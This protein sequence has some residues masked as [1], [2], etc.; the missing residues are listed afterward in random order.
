MFDMNGDGKFDE[1]DSVIDQNGDRLPVSG[2]GSSGAIPTG[3][4]DLL[5]GQ[6][7]WL[8]RGTGVDDCIPAANTLDTL[9][10]RQSWNQIR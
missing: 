3:S 2:L 9:E 10:G 5:G 4:F 1:A 8:C 7:Y 6:K